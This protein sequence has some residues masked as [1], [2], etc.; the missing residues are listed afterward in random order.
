[1]PRRTADHLEIGALEFVEPDLPVPIIGI[2]ADRVIG[3]RARRIRAFGHPDRGIP[4]ALYR[5]PTIDRRARLQ[6]GDLDAYLRQLR[7]EESA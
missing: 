5:R 1:M 3:L 7:S 6:D 2:V 4:E